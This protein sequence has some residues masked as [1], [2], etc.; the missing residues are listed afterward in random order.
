VLNKL[1][2]ALSRERAL[3]YTS[4]WCLIRDLFMRWEHTF[5]PHSVDGMAAGDGSNAQLPMFWSR[6]D[7]FMAQ[8]LQGHNVWLNVDF[9]VC[10]PALAHICEQR[11][12]H[13]G[14]VGAT[15]VV[16]YTP[17]KWWWR[18]YARHAELAHL[19][20]A[21]TKLFTAHRADA[22]VRDAPRALQGPCPFPVAVLRFHN[23]P[24]P[25]PHRRILRAGDR[26]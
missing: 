7:N 25:N 8:S 3:A 1:A 17:A 21:G 15:V 13:P 11:A 9:R 6:Q 20:P 24:T 2:D 14:Q 22:Q 12:L 16:P 4:D 23:H 19:Y 26:G 18:M 10:G 5:G